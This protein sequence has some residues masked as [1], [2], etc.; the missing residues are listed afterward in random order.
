MYLDALWMQAGV[1]LRN[2]SHRYNWAFRKGPLVSR[3]QFIVFRVLVGEHIKE[4][5]SEKQPA[6][7]EEFLH[8]IGNLSIPGI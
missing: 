6:S 3:Y 7:L 1:K 8:E 4:T 2:F 5:Q